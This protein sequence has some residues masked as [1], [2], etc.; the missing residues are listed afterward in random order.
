MRELISMLAATK[1]VNERMSEAIIPQ[2]NLQEV[3]TFMQEPMPYA[4]MTALAVALKDEA[5]EAIIDPTNIDVDWNQ[6]LLAQVSWRELNEE[7][8]IKR[9]DK[10]LAAGADPTPTTT[11]SLSS[12][13]LPGACT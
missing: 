5:Q 8:C 11:R 1:I 13:Q 12:Q 4:W 9:Q 6:Q 7:F 3:D 10:I 2:L